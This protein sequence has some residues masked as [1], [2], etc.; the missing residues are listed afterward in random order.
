MPT[1][2]SVAFACGQIVSRH[3]HALASSEK[4][5]EGFI[6]RAALAALESRHDAE[7]SLRRRFLLT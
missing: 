3:A 7:G 5:E 6:A 1:L 4:G 2:F